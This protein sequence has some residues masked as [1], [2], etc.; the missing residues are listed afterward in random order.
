MG[1][2]RPPRPITKDFMRMS[3]AMWDLVQRCWAQQPADRPSAPT[4]A[5]DLKGIIDA[6]QAGDRADVQC[7]KEQPTNAAAPPGPKGLAEPLAVDPAAMAD[8]AHALGTLDV[9][10]PPPVPEVATPTVPSFATEDRT[11]TAEHATNASGTETQADTQTS[12]ITAPELPSKAES[13]PESPE[14]KQE[15]TVTP[16]SKPQAQHVPEDDDARGGVC[17]CHCVIA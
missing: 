13:Q 16:P 15:P 11:T 4:V 14:S 7:D 9:A 10:P 5:L 2:N 3:N 1:G 12:Q 8:A 17:G 6:E